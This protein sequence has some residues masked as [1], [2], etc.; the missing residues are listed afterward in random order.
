MENN[1]EMLAKKIAEY[2]VERGLCDHETIQA[3]LKRQA[4]LRAEGIYKPLGTVLIDSNDLSIS[5]LDDCLNLMYIDVLS[6][7]PFYREFSR[8]TLENLVSVVDRQVL[9]PGVDIIKQGD[10]G[11]TSFVVISGKVKVYAISEDDVE[12]ELATLGGGDGFGEMT[13]LTGEPRSASVKTLESTSLLILS[14]DHFDQFC[15]NHPEWALAIIKILSER[16]TRGNVDLVTASES[17]RAYENFVS[18]QT[19]MP[20]S[21]LV[22]ETRSIK[23]LRERI[24]EVARNDR[25]ILIIGEEGTEKKV[26]ANLIHTQS[27]R[28]DSPFLAM[29]ARTVPLGGT[30]SDPVSQVPGDILQL[31]MAQTSAL[32]GHEQGALS[33]AKTRRLGLLHVCKKGT[34]VIENIEKLT[35]DVQN[36]LHEFIL[37]NSFKPMGAREPTSSSARILATT[38]VDLDELV[39][40]NRFS[41]P[42]Y[43]MLDQQ[44][45]TLRPLRRRKSDLRLIIDDMIERYNETGTKTVAGIAPDAYQRIMLYD[46]P[47]NMEEL[48]VVLRR[49]LNLTKSDYLQ[50]EGIFIGMAP[51]Q[52]KHTFNLF[53]LDKVRQLFTSRAFPGIP[54]AIIALF[55]SM[56]FLFAFFGNQSPDQNISVLLVWALWWPFF[57]LSCF[58]AGRIWCSVCPM[59]LPG[60][61]FNRYFSFKLKVPTLIRRYG[62]FASAV[63]FAVI[64]WAEAGSKMPF[65]PRAT[66]ILL[67]TLTICA[68]LSGLFFERRA[69]CRYICPLGRMA[70]VFSTCSMVEWRSNNSI[71]NST[72]KTHECYAGTD[73]APGCPLYQ[74]PFSLRSNQN[75][76]FCGN[77][78]KICPDKSPSLSL[79][80]PGHELWALIKPERAMLIFLPVVAGTQLFRGI[81]QIQFFHAF[82]AG[83]GYRWMMLGFLLMAATGIFFLFTIFAG[84]LVFGPLKDTTVSK[85]ALFIYSLVPLVFAFEA[86]FHFDPLVGRLG[87]FFPV[88]GTYFGFDWKLFDFA[89]AP[90]AASPWQVIIIIAGTV[91][92]LFILGRLLKKHQKDGE[93]GLNLQKSMPTFLLAATYIWIFLLK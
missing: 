18:Q 51:A 59:A 7:A 42:L 75:C 30:E 52:G 39:K 24:K 49:A 77:C 89:F 64:I 25:P 72:C 1:G 36:K 19:N 5:D 6:S 84:R 80:I 21:T 67:L 60:T 87:H 3:A 69:W 83:T 23:K 86:S 33:F 54:Q 46:W 47:G 32:F 14:K 90:A 56:L 81:E 28:D 74:G 29:N 13:L 26:V 45:L 70:G 68:A 40:K 2:L 15:A 50:P 53:K 10:A 8:D 73:D 61:L 17:E 37:S 38:A 48:E 31:E 43:E 88:L 57:I 44:S 85:G 82:G 20:T 35:I 55:F 65:S 22:G 63:G 62:I 9:P 93:L 78:F 41:Q 76:S 12:T 92:S 34:V 79:R 4:T 71:C 58:F 27:S 91:F 11:D 66:G 16:I